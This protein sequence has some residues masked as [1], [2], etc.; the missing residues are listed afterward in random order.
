MRR[1]R[2]RKLGRAMGRN[3]RL[4]TR[5]NLV[6]VLAVSLCGMLADVGS[7]FG[8]TLI[9]QREQ[10]RQAVNHVRAG[11]ITAARNIQKQL[12]DYPLAP[13]ITYHHLR[14]RLAQ[15]TPDEVNQFRSAHPDIPGAHRIYQQWLAQL[16]INRK[17]RTFLAHYEPPNANERIATELRC[18]YVRALYNRGEKSRALDEVTALWT[19]G[20]SQPKVCDPM[21][22]VW[23]SARLDQKTGWQRLRLAIAENQ[24]LLARYLQRFLTGEHRIWAQSYYSVHVNPANIARTSRFT[25]DSALSREVIAHGLRRLARRDP[26]AARD[27]WASYKASHSFSATEQSAIGTHIDIELA[28]EGLL[29]KAPTAESPPEHALGFANAYLMQQNWPLLSAW[30]E[31]MPEAERLE[32]NWQYWLARALSITH[33]SSNRAPLI[34]QALADKRSYYGFLAAD[35]IGQPP[36]LNAAQRPTDAADIGNV[37]QLPGIARALE[38]FSVGDEVNARREW[39]AMLPRLT[40]AE[41]SIAIFLIYDIGELE[42]AIRTATRTGQTDHLEVRFPIEYEQIFR[43]Q[44]HLTGVPLSLLLAFARQESIFNRYAR[45]SANAR[46]VMQMLHSTARATARR[47]GRSSPSLSDLYDPNINI[48][49][50]S[51]HIADL[52]KRYRQVMPVAAA[53][54]NAGEGRAN[55]WIKA[56]QGWPMDVWIESI[57][58]YETR[59]YVKSLVAFNQVYSQLLGQ[60]LPVL[61]EHERT[62]TLR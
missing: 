59:N 27:A 49:L 8:K 42:L 30:I 33:E 7:A 16:A 26:K 20:K 61:H 52:L 22:Q 15:L 58:F 40:P 23:Q 19:V 48:P 14:L 55:R 32:E 13:Y 53:A 39:L 36:Q 21:F 10:Y 31:Q 62:I 60:P 41:Q 11:R 9:E 28:R 51:I 47:A 5:R 38:L 24:R 43:R 44:S 12:G 1:V 25:A 2:S 17:W 6:C 50:G 46:G 3:R 18:H 56:A 34:Y 54:Y 37:R 29:E 35:Q 45:S 4:V 57:P